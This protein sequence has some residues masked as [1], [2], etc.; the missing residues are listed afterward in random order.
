[1]GTPLLLL[2]LL[3]QVIVKGKTSRS[4][5][6]KDD[7][8]TTEGM[9]FHYTFS[10]NHWANKDTMY[11]W[12]D[13]VLAPYLKQTVAALDAKLPEDRKLP[14]DQKAILIIDCWKVHLTQASTY[15]AVLAGLG[16]AGLGWDAVVL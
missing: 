1:M 3:V 2:L 5:P 16:W 9:G 12:V 8:V 11:Q 4:L 6:P 15:T 14:A 7:R 10:D 13:T